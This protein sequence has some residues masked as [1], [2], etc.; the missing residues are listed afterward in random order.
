M[1]KF[2]VLFVITLV[3]LCGCSNDDNKDEVK[4]EVEKI[5]CDTMKEYMKG[6][7]TVLVDVRTESEYNEKHLPDAIN[8]PYDNILEGSKESGAI[9]INTKII[10][11]C[12][13]GKRSSIAAD[14]LA[15]A[16][17]KYVYDLGA[18]SNCDK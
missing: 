3:F 5:S 10:V 2:L 7:N 16:G 1:K 14:E 12:K 4:L 17:F 8:I 9:D 6:S 13:S 18:M 11:Y 15:K